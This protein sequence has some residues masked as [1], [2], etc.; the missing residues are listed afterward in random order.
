M[1][2]ESVPRSFNE[3]AESTLQRLEYRCATTAPD[4]EEI[5]RLRYDGYT[6]EG[7]IEAD[8]TGRFKDSWDDTPNAYLIGAWLDGV[9]AA[10]V[11]I[12]VSAQGEEIPACGPFGDVVRPFL[13]HGLCLVDATRFVVDRRHAAFSAEMPFL[14]LRAVAMAAEHFRAFG[15]LA[16]VRQEHAIVYRRV[17]GHRALSEARTYPLLRKPI[18][19]MLAETADLADKPYAKHPFLKSNDSERARLFCQT[20]SFQSAMPPPAAMESLSRGFNNATAP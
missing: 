1:G 18:M 6:R 2:T 20:A 13:D 12:H 8:G 4:R 16:T 14:I 10:T 7:G 17:T 9:L 5:F 3:R 19:C 11:R 15:L